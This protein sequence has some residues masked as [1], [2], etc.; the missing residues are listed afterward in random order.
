MLKD[1]FK[2][3]EKAAEELEKSLMKPSI[4]TEIAKELL[5]RFPIENILNQGI[6]KDELDKITFSE[7]EDG[8]QINFNIGHQYVEGSI[9]VAV[10]KAERKL[11]VRADFQKNGY[12][13]STEFKVLVPVGYNVEAPKT[14]VKNGVVKV[15]FPVK[16][17]VVETTVS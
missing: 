11:T 6:F 4:K 12:S 16:E 15:S 7:N 5:K 1:L 9:N 3:V 17:E 8:I 2:T 10:K 13:E 14:T